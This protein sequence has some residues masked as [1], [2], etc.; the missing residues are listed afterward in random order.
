MR[1]NKSVERVS[2]VWAKQS[3]VPEWMR[4]FDADEMVEVERRYVLN[5]VY[6]VSMNRVAS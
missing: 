5:M 1:S 6:V 4:Q 3:V 2:D